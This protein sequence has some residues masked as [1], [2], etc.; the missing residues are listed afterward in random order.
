MNNQLDR[1]E[2][3]N[4]LGLLPLT[5]FVS[6]GPSTRKMAKT[7]DSPNIIIIV[8]DAFSGHNISLYGYPRLTTPFLSSLAE[9]AIVYHNHYAPANF[10][11]PGTASLLTGTYPW[12]HRAIQINSTV[13]PHL[14][15]R[16]FYHLF[17]DYYT[18]TYSHNQLVNILQKDFEVDID[19]LKPRGDLT[20]GEN[21]W[22]SKLFAKDED[23][24]TVAWARASGNVEDNL[25]NTLF[26]QDIIKRFTDRKAQRIERDFPLG[27]PL[28]SLDY[29]M[30]ED[31]VNWLINEADILPQPFLGY[32][33]FL[34]PHAPYNTR[35]QFIDAFQNSDITIKSKPKHPLAKPGRVKQEYSLDHY[36]RTY[37]EYILYVDSEFNRLYKAL[38]EGGILDNT[39]LILTS[40]HGEMFERGIL[41]HSTPSL[42]DP[43]LR[44]PLL[45]FP[46]GQLSRRDIYSNTSAVDLL[47]TL[48]SLAGRPIPSWIEGSVLPPYREPDQKRCIY[49]LEA[50]TNKPSDPLRSASAM[51][52]QGPYK[53]THYFGYGFLPRGEPLIELYDLQ[54]DPEEMNNLVESSSHL[55]GGLLAQLEMRI[56]T[57]EEAFKAAR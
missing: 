28:S 21:K 41:G 5:Y 44:I 24:A 13:A 22:L 35:R 3:I 16:N 55:A 27:L 11:T 57:A 25:S 49:A 52:L 48:L 2:F 7:I 50:K 46:P 4:L 19:Y 10:T 23:I 20:L 14:Q 45:I 31:A 42:H 30:L 38:D 34:P 9:K 29:F 6:R 47:P 54:N 15:T 40:D 56:Q 33:H 39:Y 26:L 36:R 18:V 43:L 8:F 1:R 37:D 17:D 12:T 32:F 51:I 53:L